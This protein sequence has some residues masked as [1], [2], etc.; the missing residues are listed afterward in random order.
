[1]KI[2]FTEKAKRFKAIDKLIASGKKYTWE[3]I[4]DKLLT[5]YKIRTSKTSF[6]RDIKELKEKYSAPIKTDPVTNGY[7]YTDPAY[8]IP[9]FYTDT[10][11]ANAAEL[12]KT[13]MEVIPDNP[14]YNEAQ[15]IFNSLSP[16]KMHYTFNGI[17]LI[18]NT[19]SDRV[20]FL[21]APNKEINPEVFRTIDRAM[22]QNLEITFNYKSYNAKESKGRIVRPYQLIYDNGNW[23]LH[24]YDTIK[25]ALR[26]YTLSKMSNLKITKTPFKLTADYDFRKLIIGNFGC[27]CEDKV[28]E[29]KIHLHGYAAAYA[30]DRIWSEDQEIKPDKKNPGPKKDG[31]ILSFES[32]QF[33]A[34]S[35]WVWQWADE[36]IPYE[37]VELV[38]DWMKRRERVMR[39]EFSKTKK[40]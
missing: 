11:A 23:N 26:R 14:L 39:V 20:I 33:L 6:F 31:I 10:D 29:Y 4:I 21:G 3:K 27:L 36:A 22:K 5:E 32:N 35:R 7:Y 9:H 15:E 19:T 16:Q 12:L 2:D 17:R 8:T 25:R 13:L 28:F 1:M 37:P 38:E 30:K 40:K 18:E 34:I 24:G